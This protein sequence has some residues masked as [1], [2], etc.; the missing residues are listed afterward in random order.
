MNNDLYV[1]IYYKYS[2]LLD[3]FIE[4]KLNY[5]KYK[6]EELLNIIYDDNKLKIFKDYNELL[7][8]DTINDICINKDNIK[9]KHN[10]YFNH[11]I[12]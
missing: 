4:Y 8:D 2:I 6:K 10:K 5:N 7:V 11:F 9:E 1:K 12:Q 3:Q